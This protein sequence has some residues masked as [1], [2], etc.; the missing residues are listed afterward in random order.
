MELFILHLVNVFVDDD[1][2]TEGARESAAKALTHFPEI[3]LQ[4]HQLFVLY[5]FATQR[6]IAITGANVNKPRILSIYPT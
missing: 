3:F 5:Q 4:Q 1:L 2:A 6:A